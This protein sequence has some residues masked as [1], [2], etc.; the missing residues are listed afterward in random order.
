MQLAGTFRQYPLTDV[1]EIIES[2]QRSGRLAAGRGGPM[3]YAYFSDG[4][5]VY[6]ERLGTGL[7]LLEQ[8]VQARLVAPE[9][10]AGVLGMRIEDT[11]AL[12]DAQVARMLVSSGVLTQDQLR[13]WATQDAIGMLA[14]MLTWTEGEF[15]F[16]DGVQAPAGQLVLPLPL[17]PLVSEALKLLRGDPVAQDVEPLP[18]DT[19]LAFADVEPQREA[20]IELTR[21]QWRLLTMVDGQLPLWAI[22]DALQA[23][24]PVLQ[25]VAATLV[26]GE[27]A[28]VVGQASPGA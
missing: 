19:V 4:Q 25:R 2:G 23:P 10:A 11:V 14:V 6:G 20:P 5:W 9:Q 21:D 18:A 7:T 24:A 28:V 15:Q 1:L 22:A 3:A 27:F 26:Q 8:L 17:S 13:A 12:P 16:E